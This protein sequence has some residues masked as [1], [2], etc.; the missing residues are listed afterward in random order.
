MNYDMGV[1]PY[2]RRTGCIDS[3]FGHVCFHP[4]HLTLDVQGLSKLYSEYILHYAWRAVAIC[5][6]LSATLGDPGLIRGGR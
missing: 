1:R 4:L 6:C 3:G 5:S 2:T